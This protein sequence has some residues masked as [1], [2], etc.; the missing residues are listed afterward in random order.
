MVEGGEL[1][2]PRPG[3]KRAVMVRAL[4]ALAVIS[5]AVAAGL[6]IVFGAAVRLRDEYREQRKLQAST[7]AASVDYRDVL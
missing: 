3:E 6:W 7:A 4:L 1:E 2:A 5:A